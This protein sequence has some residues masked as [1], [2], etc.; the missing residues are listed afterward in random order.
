MSK[1][2]RFKTHCDSQQVKGCQTL[3]KSAEKHIYAFVWSLWEKL[4]WRTSLLANYLLT[5]WLPKTSIFF[6]IGRIQGNQFKWS[7]LETI[8]RSSIF[9]CISAIELNFEHFAKKDEPRSLCVPE[10]K[11]S[12]TRGYL[13]I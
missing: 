5:Q 12:Q 13:N 4:S 10:I 11:D 3:L 2:P 7:Y 9:C 6:I 1:M 8:N